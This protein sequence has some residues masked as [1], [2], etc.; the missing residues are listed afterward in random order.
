MLKFQAQNDFL[1]LFDDKTNKV[2]KSEKL[3]NSGSTIIAEV[4]IRTWAKKNG[5]EIN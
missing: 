4:K 5:L 2:V 3:P 1:I